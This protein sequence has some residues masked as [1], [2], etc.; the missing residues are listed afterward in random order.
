VFATVANT[1]YTVIGTDILTGC[2]G[3]VTTSVTV[4]GS[5]TLTHYLNFSSSTIPTVCIGGNLLGFVNGGIANQYTWTAPGNTVVG[6]NVTLNPTI[7]GPYTIT[8]NNGACISSTISQNVVVDPGPTMTVTPSISTASI[9]AGT[10]TV[11]IAT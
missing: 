8:A 10:S 3:S 4:T 1:T 5:L 7:T 9:C 2:T 11:I 6:A